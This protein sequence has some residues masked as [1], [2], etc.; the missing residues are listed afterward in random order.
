M[1]Y[2]SR[3]VLPVNTRKHHINHIHPLF[4]KT[5]GSF[6]KSLRPDLHFIMFIVWVL[7]QRLIAEKK[8]ITHRHK[9][10]WQSMDTFKDKMM[11]DELQDKGNPPWQLWK[12]D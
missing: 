2:Q 7:F 6:S 10:F 3:T 11:L 8:L 4:A 12:K 9:G 1:Y 5:I